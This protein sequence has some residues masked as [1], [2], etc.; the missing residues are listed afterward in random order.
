MICAGVH[1][2]KRD[3][4]IPANNSVRLALHRHSLCALCGYG[5]PLEGQSI[6]LL[7]ASW[8]ANPSTGSYAGNVGEHP[9]IWT[10]HSFWLPCE[11]KRN[12]PIPN[13]S[14][15]NR[16]ISQCMPIAFIKD[17]PNI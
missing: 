10:R 16:Y 14:C 3:E 12:G 5:S 13:P 9:C 7:P 17:V 4:T 8:L 2:V 6:H 11:S 15:S 1:L